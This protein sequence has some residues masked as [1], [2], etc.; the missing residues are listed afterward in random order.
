M[1]VESSFTPCPQNIIDG[2]A[3]VDF[4]VNGCQYGTIQWDKQ[5]LTEILVTQAEGVRQDLF[6]GDSRPD[7]LTQFQAK[8]TPNQEYCQ[9][10]DW[11]VSDA[12]ERINL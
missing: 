5:G 7:V 9:T 12:G 6:T 1:W 3:S 10:F 4:T 2:F 11:C 8:Y